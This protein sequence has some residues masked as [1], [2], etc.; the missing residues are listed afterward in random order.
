[1]RALVCENCI[2]NLW[3][4]CMFLISAVECFSDTPPGI[5]DK[6]YT[7]GSC[8]DSEKSAVAIYRDVDGNETG[9]ESP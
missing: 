8:D 6:L 3:L 1:M 9:F 2:V 4:Q 7:D 5:L